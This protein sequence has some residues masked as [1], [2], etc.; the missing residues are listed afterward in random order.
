[1]KKER[2]RPLDLALVNLPFAAVTMPSIQLGV[3]HAA[4][5]QAGLRVRTFHLNL[6][7]LR[8]LDARSDAAQRARNLRFV[9]DGETGFSDSHAFAMSTAPLFGAADRRAKP[10]TDPGGPPP[11]DAAY[12]DRI[13]PWARP[14]SGSCDPVHADTAAF[15]HRLFPEFID[16]CAALLLAHDPGAVG[17]SC[18]FERLPQLQLASRLKQLRPSLWTIFGGTHV[19]GV[20]G[21][22][23]CRAFPFVDIVVRGD[24]EATLVQVLDDLRSGQVRPHDGLVWRD[25]DGSSEPHAVQEAPLPPGRLVAPTPDYGDYFAQ[26][27]GTE[28]ESSGDIQLPI[29]TS[30]GCR[31]FRHKCLFCGRS[32][33]HL[34]YRAKS[35]EQVSDELALLSARHRTLRF[36]CVDSC[37]DEKQMAQVAD[38]AKESGHDYQLWCQGRVF[39]DRETHR[40]LSTLAHTMFLG[41][42]SLSTPVLKLMRKGH[43]ALQALVALKRAAENGL[44]PTYNLLHGFPGEREEHYRRLNDWLPAF[45][46]LP[47]PFQLDAM[48]ICRASVYFDRPADFGIRLHPPMPDRDPVLRLAESAGVSRQR[49]WDLAAGVPAD[50]PCVSGEPIERCRALVAAWRDGYADDA[51]ALWWQRGPDFLV[52]HDERAGATN[53]FELPAPFDRL[54]LATDEGATIEEIEARLAA[55]G[56][57]T[58]RAKIQETVT[59]LVAERLMYEEDGTFLSL[60]LGRRRADRVGVESRP[61]GS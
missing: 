43:T 59:D 5:D 58:P 54:Y 37:V 27:L 26:V 22:A 41:I 49:L 61:S 53:R 14:A 11:D 20:M 12:V 56:C 23:L 17:F 10:G 42:E 55:A 36:V 28:I 16:H 9:L 31:W 45:C 15:I 7:L 3:L 33:A 21:E 51:G 4:V 32:E 52:I 47:P 29:E 39:T 18:T 57:E 34:R 1:M 2:R 25:R 6:E 30:R 46:H 8:F 48:V 40:R 24:G 13:F 60:A 38:E 50:I 44:C 35:R 19:E